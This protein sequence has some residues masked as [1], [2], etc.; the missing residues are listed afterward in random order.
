[1]LATNLTVTVVTALLFTTLT[2]LI[3]KR[4]FDK[5]C[6]KQCDKSKRVCG[7]FCKLLCKKK[8]KSPIIELVSENEENEKG[9]NVYGKIVKSEADTTRDSQIQPEESKEQPK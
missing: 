6:K 2:V 8:F 7:K 5:C 9:A 3:L 1:V 4:V